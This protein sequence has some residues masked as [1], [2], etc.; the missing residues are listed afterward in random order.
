MEDIY[1]VY[2]LYSP[3]FDQIYIGYTSN[4]IQRFYSHNELA[5]K[6][7][8]IKYRPWIVCYA[9][10]FTQKSKALIREKQ[11]KSYQGRK[12]IRDLVL[13]SYNF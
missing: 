12:F 4:L 2:V 6:G 8:T 11:L 3:T 7:H 5:V 10:Y 9:E 13:P 1:T